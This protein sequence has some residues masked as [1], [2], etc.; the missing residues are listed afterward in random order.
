MGC[1]SCLNIRTLSHRLNQGRLGNQMFQ[2]AAVYGIATKNNI[3]PII[4]NWAYI[5]HFNLSNSIIGTPRGQQINEQGYAYQNIEVGKGGILSGYFQSYKYFEQVQNVVRWFFQPKR[6]KFQQQQN[7]T[8][9]HIRRTDY[10]S[11][12]CQEVLGVDYYNAAIEQIKPTRL[13]VFSDDII[14]AK[15]NIK[16][17]IEIEYSTRN[18]LEDLELMSR[19]DSHI[20]ANSTFS[21]WGAYLAN[22]K[23]VISPSKWFKGDCANHDIKDLNLPH[24]KLI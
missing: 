16:P 14:W 7:T 2:I 3:K 19:C 11:G 1:K 9:L 18:E 17:G 8:A 21:W 5:N 23:R 24:W 4:P 22:S 13:I 12:N 10:L 6:P 20:I 15:E